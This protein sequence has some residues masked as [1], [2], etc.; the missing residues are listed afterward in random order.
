MPEPVDET[1]ILILTGPPGVGKTT[2]AAAVAK[3]SARSVHLESDAF[4][5]FIRCGYVE[6]WRQE[7]HRQNRAVMRIIA[8]AGTGYA[9]AGY[10]TLIDGIVTP[11][12]FFEPL[13]DAL[14]EAGHRVAFAVLRAPLSVCI[15]RARERADQPLEN[16]EVV[17]QLWRS[18]AD[19]GELEPHA[20]DLDGESPET[21]AEI[22]GERLSDGSLLV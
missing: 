7:S 5:H 13:R 18:F 15:A 22:L 1:P 21:V 3:R 14:H 4:F 9:E 16:P 8:R 17:E 10:F 19:L 2:T 6:P 20:L 12:W 11:G